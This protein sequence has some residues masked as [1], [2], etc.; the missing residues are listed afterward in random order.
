[1]P[2]AL[3]A[4]SYILFCVLFGGPVGKRNDSQEVTGPQ[5]KLSLQRAM[6]GPP[7]MVV[8]V[9]QANFC[10]RQEEG[11]DVRSKAVLGRLHHGYCLAPAV[12]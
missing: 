3:C 7:R 5:N 4:M 6:P 11:L 12:A 9:R 10:Q 8:S 1:M 2:D